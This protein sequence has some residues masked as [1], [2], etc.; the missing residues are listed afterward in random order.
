MADDFCDFEQYMLHS[1]YTWSSIEQLRPHFPRWRRFL[2]EQGVDRV[3]KSDATASNLMISVLEDA[4]PGGRR[5]QGV[6]HNIRNIL[7]RQGA[8]AFSKRGWKN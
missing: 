3:L 7:S 2:R 1:G 4:A 8:P 5:D 6:L